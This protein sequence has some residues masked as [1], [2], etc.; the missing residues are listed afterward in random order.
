[1]VNL[2][3]K[4]NLVTGAQNW[5]GAT[6]LSGKIS[7]VH[8]KSDLFIRAEITQKNSTDKVSLRLAGPKG[9]FI[10][11]DKQEETQ[12]ASGGTRRKLLLARFSLNKLK[13]YKQEQY[14]QSAPAYDILGLSV[15]LVQSRGA[16]PEIVLSTSIDKEKHQGN[17]RLANSAKL[18]TLE[19]F[20]WKNCD[21]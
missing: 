15:Q 7:G 6:T 17:I 8:T 2:E 9:K 19:N 3:N 1:M 18:A 14:G 12:I 11:P 16:A 4:W 13:Q 21:W 10:A 20:D 5:K